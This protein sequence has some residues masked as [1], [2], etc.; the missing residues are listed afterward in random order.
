MKTRPITWRDIFYT[1]KHGGNPS[2]TDIVAALR[3]QAR[4]TIGFQ[5]PFGCILLISWTTSLTDAVALAWARWQRMSRQ[6][7]W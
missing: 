6:R 7:D 4:T 3:H 2:K 5:R 1:I